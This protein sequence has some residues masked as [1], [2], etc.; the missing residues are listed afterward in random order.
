MR[1]KIEYTHNGSFFKS[2]GLLFRSLFNLAAFVF[3]WYTLL[4]PNIALVV[5]STAVLTVAVLLNFIFPI[6]KK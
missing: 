4:V 3:F 2:F 6:V 5:A 1:R